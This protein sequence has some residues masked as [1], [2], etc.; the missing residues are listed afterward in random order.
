MDDQVAS[1]S[2]EHHSLPLVVRHEKHG[3]ARQDG[4]G[5]LQSIP[6]QAWAGGN[7]RNLQAGFSTDLLAPPDQA[8]TYRRYCLAPTQPST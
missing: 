2:Q 6:L 7:F 1:Q 3:V 5:Q 4:D 8:S